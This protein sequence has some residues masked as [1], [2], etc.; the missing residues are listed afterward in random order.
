MLEWEIK[1][2]CRWWNGL[3]DLKVTSNDDQIDIVPA[4][5]LSFNSEELVD[6]IKAA[7]SL[8]YAVSTLT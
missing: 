2:S 6:F 8:L 1:S 5:G 3:T 4:F 7:V